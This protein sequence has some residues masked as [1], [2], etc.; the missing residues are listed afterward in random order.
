MEQ[1]SAAAGR[2]A[3][4][5]GPGRRGTRGRAVDLR[6]RLAGARPFW[7]GGRCVP[8]GGRE[9]VRGLAMILLVLLL[10]PTAAKGQAL[11]MPSA[12][13]GRLRADHIR[14]DAK[15]KAYLAEGDVRLTLGD[16]E[17]RA[18]RLRLEHESQIAYVF[19]EVTVQQGDTVLSARNVTYDLTRKLARALGDPVLRQ[20][21]TTVRADR[22]EFDL[23]RRRTFFHGA[24]RIVHKDVTVSAP[25]MR[26]DASVDEAIAPD[27]VVSQPGRTV[28]AHR[29]R[30]LPQ[31]GRLELE[32]SVVV[33]Q[34]S[35]ARLVEEGVIQ[36]PDDTEAQGL[37]SSAA[38]LTCDR[39]IILTGERTARA[40]GNLLVKHQGRSAS[41]AAALYADRE[42][43]L[44]MTGSVVLLDKDGRRLR[45]DMVVISLADETVEATGNVVT[46]FIL[47]RK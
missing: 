33:E 10:L 46:E 29:L 8:I 38:L 15:A 28:H 4:G 1:C 6:H 7:G 42:R 41:A 5:D 9:T 27:V 23:E 26:Y 35:G 12:D 18:Q 36:S 11:Q 19:G 3:S 22:M 39:L 25:E 16:A 21:G 17:V 2:P 13:Q 40:E 37:L 43:R 47:R 34:E 45:A 31:A 30:Y 20:G 24:V 14:Y 32:G 44:T